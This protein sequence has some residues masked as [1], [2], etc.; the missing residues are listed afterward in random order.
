MNF[1]I[2]PVNSN[3]INTADQF[4]L[5]K[6]AQVSAQKISKIVFQSIAMLT[7]SGDSG[8]SLESLA[9]LKKL[10]EDKGLTEN[11][12]YTLVN[13]LMDKFGAL[14][15][16][17]KTIS[18]DDFLKTIKFSVAQDFSETTDLYSVLRPKGYDFSKDLISIY[19]QTNLETLDLMLI[20][21]SLSDETINKIIANLNSKTEPSKTSGATLK[22]E[23]TKSTAVTNPYEP[24]DYKTI[25]PEQLKTPISITV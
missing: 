11:S 25:T 19:G 12:A 23:V 10:I 20:M 15:S 17:G 4:N 8:I 14:S 1:A 16:D 3:T 9:S 2:N 18:E 7:N 13:T 5:Y 22:A 6:K 24:Q 21:D